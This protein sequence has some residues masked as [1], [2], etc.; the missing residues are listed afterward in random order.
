[1]FA[2][3][4]APSFT[5]RS[6]LPIA[7]EAFWRGMSMQV[8]NAELHP[9][10]SMTAP[11]AWK[12]APLEQWTTGTVLFRS[13]ILLFGFLPVDVHSLRLDSIVPARGFLERSHS[14]CNALWQHE[15]STA[16]TEAGCVV[17]DTITVQGRVPLA[18]ALLMPVYRMVFR[19]RH[20]RMKALYGQA[21]PH[22]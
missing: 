11:A 21:A 6:E 7:P 4:T 18:A 15:R 10:V 19:H 12:A 16:R 2:M 8:V 1:M 22:A 17:T 13:V 14:W 3:M 5:V 9:L 20:R